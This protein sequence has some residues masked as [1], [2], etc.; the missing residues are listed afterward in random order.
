MIL[1]DTTRASAAAA[2][3]NRATLDDLFRRALMR[4]PQTIALADPPN[5]ESFTDGAPRRLTYLEAD[6]VISAIAARL[7]RLGLQTDAIVG[8]QL[9]NTVESVLM[10]LGTLRAGMIAVPL[11]MLWRK[12]DAVAA[13]GRIG[14][15]ALVTTSHIGTAAHCDLAMQVAAELFPIRY[16]GGFGNNLPDGVVPF[17]DLFNSGKLDPLPAI[18]RAGNPAA[19][20]AAVTFDVT[21]Q[22]LTPVARNHMELIA[23]GLSVFL[24]SRAEQDHGVLSAI[25][26]SSFAGIALSVVPWLLTGGTLALHQPFD[27]AFFAAQ[28]REHRSETIVLPGQLVARLAEAEHFTKDDGAKCIVGLWRAP[29][30]LAANAPWR[31]TAGLLDVLAFGEIGLLAARRGTSGKPAQIGFGPIGA[32]RG[33]PNAMLVADVAPTD[34]GTVALRGPMVPSHAFPP[35]AERSQLP[36]LKIDRDG[37]I[38]TGYTCRSERD[39]RALVVTGPPAG[40]V[41]VGGYR[42]LLREVTAAVEGVEPGGTF[43]ALPDAITGYRLAGSAPDRT[44]LRQ[45]LGAL[46]LNPLVSG[47]FRERGAANAA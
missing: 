19:H 13:L 11:P 17:E 24:E 35:G 47:A 44:A 30:R 10:L 26:V 36:H 32:P 4:H 1:G 31:E 28:S 41:G 3:G 6:R 40:I 14:A 42:F 34:A 46:G 39:T 25:P 38:D 7:R 29:E 9:P 20:L 12:A 21:P 5:R 33:S 37:F 22:G 2:A 23:G 18:E 8:I 15:K 27:P 16:V 45:K 43:A